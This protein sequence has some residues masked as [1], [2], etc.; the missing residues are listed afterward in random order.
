MSILIVDDMRDNQDLLRY[1]LKSAGYRDVAVVGS[2]T[3]AF[4]VLGVDE[5]AV[6]RERID[7]EL[8]LMDIMMPHI[9]G[10][11]ACRRIK[12]VER[13]RD[14]PI[15]MVTA[16]TEPKD[17]EQAF[18]VGAMDFMTKPVMAIELL[19]RVRSALAL[20]AAM[21]IRK[22][23]EEELAGK[24]QELEQTLKEIKVLRGL[25]PICATCKKIRDDQGYWQLLETYIAQHSEAQFSHGICLECMAK[26]YPRFAPHSSD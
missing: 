23:H 12:S 9:S 5:P 3:E 19:A 11:E 2:A 4:Q 6:E 14:I 13:L 18:S 17:L 1:L 26:F 10:I 21:D 22:A 8:I 20:K 16:K 25:I 24:N 7:I 15:I